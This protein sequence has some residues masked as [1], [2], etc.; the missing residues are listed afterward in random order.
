MRSLREGIR[1][2]LDG[3]A[4]VLDL[5]ATFRRPP[6]RYTRDTRS[7]EEALRADARAVDADGAK[8][9]GQL[10]HYDISDREFNAIAFCTGTECNYSRSTDEWLQVTCPACHHKRAPEKAPLSHNEHLT[11]RRATGPGTSRPLSN[12]EL[13]DDY[14]AMRAQGWGK[15]WYR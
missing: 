3:V 6:R 14:R 12:E 5:G 4:R 11:K 1:A 8:S 9:R 15:N 13:A 2:L 7:V 10:T